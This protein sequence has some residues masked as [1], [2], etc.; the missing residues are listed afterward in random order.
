MAKWGEKSERWIVND[1][2]KEGSNVNG[3]HWQEQNKLPWS[4]QRIDELVRGLGT[5]L[6]A[7]IGSAEIE[8]VKDLTGEAYLTRRKKDKIFAVYDLT[9][10]LGWCGHWVENDKKV[11]GEI[12]IKE[13]SSIDP[14]EYAFEVS[15][16]KG[17]DAPTAAANLKVAV[18]GLE[19]DILRQLQRYV[20]ELNA[21]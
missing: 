11:A 12:T 18:Q 21:L 2:G 17:E 20:Q 13:F 1:L 6:D 16:E 4:K 14:D 5:Q 10:V 7:S 19:K 8:G 9:I 15:V 3:W